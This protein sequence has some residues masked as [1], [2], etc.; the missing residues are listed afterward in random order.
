MF[1][2]LIVF[3]WGRI[4]NWDWFVTFQH[5][6]Q[7]CEYSL[8]SVTYIPLQF[9]TGIDYGNWKVLYAAY[10]CNKSITF[11]RIFLYLNRHTWNKQLIYNNYK[12][13]SLP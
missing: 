4:A 3:I 11:E 12:R 13:V 7:D 1:V 6:N 9:V 10:I 8:I 5:K 2:I